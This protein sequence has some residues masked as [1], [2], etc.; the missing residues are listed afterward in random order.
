MYNQC[1]PIDEKLL[2]YRFMARWVNDAAAQKGLADLTAEWTQ[3]SLDASSH[4]GNAN[5]LHLAWII[6]HGVRWAFTECDPSL[7][8]RA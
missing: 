4:H 1:G 8:H 5:G 3:W 6:F 2:R 7:L